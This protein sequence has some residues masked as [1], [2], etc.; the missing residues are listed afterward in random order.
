MSETTSAGIERR[1][2]TN[3]DT[4]NS[5][6][7]STF[8]TDGGSGGGG[9]GLSTS[10]KIALGVGIP[11]GIAGIVAIIV[12]WYKYCYKRKPSKQDHH[13]A[14]QRSPTFIVPRPAVAEMD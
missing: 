7:G 4:F 12:A 14:N 9:G 3:R 1:D 6:S 13:Q 11:S 10:D 8:T 5:S 2:L